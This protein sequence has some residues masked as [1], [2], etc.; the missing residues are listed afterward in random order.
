MG[1]HVSHG[2]WI[3]SYGA[4]MAWRKR[5]AQVAE[6]PPLELMEGF[7]KPIDENRRIFAFDVPTL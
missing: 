3:G 2:A 4:F 7:Y 5:V 1:L 6:L